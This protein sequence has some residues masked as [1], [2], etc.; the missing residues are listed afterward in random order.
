MKANH[1]SES[2]TA[3][4]AGG[5]RGEGFASAAVLLAAITLLVMGRLCFN[6]F[7]SWDDGDTVFSNP[8]LNPPTLTGVQFYWLHSAHRIYTPLAYTVWAA[9]ALIARVSPDPQ[10]VT[11]NPA[12]FHSANVLLHILAALV[13]CRILFLIEMHWFAVLC[14]SLIFAIHPI[15]VEAVAWVSGLKDVLSGTLAL[16]SLWQ[17][18]VFAQTDRDGHRPTIPLLL[19]ILFLI[20]AMLAKSSAATVPLAAVAIDLWIVHRRWK[21]VLSSAVILVLAAIPFI[22]IARIAQ[23]AGDITRAPLWQRPLIVAD[24]VTFYFRKLTW[25]MNLCMDYGRTP[26][27]A[28][29]QPWIYAAWLVPAALILALIAARKIAPTLVAAAAIFVAGCLPTL[30]VVPF[31]TQFYSTTADHYLYWAMLG[32]ATA[33]G[34]V[35]TKI[36]AKAIARIFIA[37]ALLGLAIS[38]IRQGGFWTDDAALFEHTLAVNP[39][40]SVAFNNL[41]NDAYNEANYPGAADFFRRSI[42]VNYDGVL[43]HSNLAA[44]LYSMGK[45][46]ESIRELQISLALQAKHPPRLR[47]NWVTDLN[48]LG[49]CLLE[50][51][52]P[53]D[54]AAAFRESLAANPDQP[55][56]PRLLSRAGSGESHAATQGGP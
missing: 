29:R 5:H 37:L 19:C 40:S 21:S 8:R 20:L 55:G 32:P 22:L 34:W 30:G 48:R 54:A 49:Q 13:V 6:E 51:G 44:A 4:A 24:S 7:V 50:T 41:G 10:G 31:A 18:F 38:S 56:I 28:M 45:S 52:N 15:Q 25:P 27:V 39:N 9:L 42:A 36:P 11:L 26:A 33:V 47:T 43:A 3:D 53:Q 2:R 14:G 12:I 16:V 35:I 17:Y 1:V 23:S 46:E